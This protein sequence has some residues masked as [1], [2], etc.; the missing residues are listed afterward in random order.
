MFRKSFC[1]FLF[2]KQMLSIVVYSWYVLQRFLRCTKWSKASKRFVIFFTYFNLV[3]RLTFAN[4]Y[5]VE[6]CQIV[7]LQECKFAACDRFSTRSLIYYRTL[8]MRRLNVNYVVTSRKF[9]YSY[10]LVDFQIMLLQSRHL[11]NDIMS[12]YFHYIK[13]QFLVVLLNS[14]RQWFRFFIHSFILVE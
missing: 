8:S 5:R 9:K 1:R 13:D 6:L 14:Y 12:D 7:L 11:Q 4:V 10:I 3:T 2:L